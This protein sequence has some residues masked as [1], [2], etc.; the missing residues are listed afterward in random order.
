VTMWAMF[1]ETSVSEL[2]VSRVSEDTKRPAHVKLCIPI[3]LQ[4]VRR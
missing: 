3:G 1:G 4:P 2:N